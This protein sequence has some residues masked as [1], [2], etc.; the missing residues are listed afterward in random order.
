MRPL[1]GTRPSS[2][3]V[4]DPA[5]RFTHLQEK[6]APR[7]LEAYRNEDFDKS[8]LSEMV[9]LRLRDGENLSSQAES[10]RPHDIQGE[11]G[12]LG[13]TIDGYGCAGVSSVAYGLIAREV[14]R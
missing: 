3:A 11:L 13:P 2:A 9:R 14:E 7:V 12:L 4:T 10:R 8:V 5:A 6:L 1:Q